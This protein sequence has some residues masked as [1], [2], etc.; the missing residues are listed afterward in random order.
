MSGNYL[1]QEGI[2][3]NSNFKRY[4]LR[5]NINADLSDKLRLST[6]LNLIRQEG[7]NND[8]GFG[9]GLALGAVGFDKTT[10]IYDVNGFYNRQT[11]VVGGV[12]ESVLTNPVFLANES[13][14]KGTTNRVQANVSLNYSLLENLD[15]NISGGIDYGNNTNAY[16]NPANNDA[17]DITAGQSTSNNTNTQYA[18][19]LNYDNTFNE[20]HNLNA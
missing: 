5:S 9:A 15:F 16:F 20:K 8:P 2:A 19:R 1:D 4:S 12:Q 6:S 18:F 17:A 14:V 13:N 10:P 7:L 3:I 11:L